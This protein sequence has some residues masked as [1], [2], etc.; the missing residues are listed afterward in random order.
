[1]SKVPKGELAKRSR[2]KIK[3]KNNVA[4]SCIGWN[5][6]MYQINIYGKFG[7]TLDTI[8][9]IRKGSHLPPL[10]ISDVRGQSKKKVT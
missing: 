9:D 10:S 3:L 2:M 5:Q 8:N 6:K 4:N 7:F 1:M